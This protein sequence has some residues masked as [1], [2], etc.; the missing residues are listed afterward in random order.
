VPPPG[1]GVPYPPGPAGGPAPKKGRA[2]V[3]VLGLSLLAVLSLLCCGG[4]FGYVG[5]YQPKQERDQNKRVYQSLGVPEGF[6]VSEPMFVGEL[7][8]LESTYYLLCEKGSCPVDPGQKIHKWL[9]ENQMTNMTLQDVQGCLAD[10]FDDTRNKL[11]VFTWQVDGKEVSVHTIWGVPDGRPDDRQ[12][13]L[14]I[15]IRSPTD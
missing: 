5:W 13:I 7:E 6:T 9:T 8:T 3:W 2:T 12:W 1:V 10:A 11:C 15:E 14:D 4:L